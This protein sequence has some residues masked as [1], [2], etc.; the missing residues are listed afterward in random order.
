MYSLPRNIWIL[1]IGLTLFMSLTVAIVFVGGI[2]G[3]TLAP[4][5]GLSTLP[6]AMVVI[7]TALSIIPVNQLM[8]KFGRRTIFLGTCLYT[9]SVIFL[10]IAALELNN[11][12]LFCV[13]AFLFGTN[14][15]VMNQF[16]FAAIESVPEHLHATAVSTVLAGGL[17]S[18][19]LAP[20]LMILGKD[21]FATAFV[22]SFLLLSCCFLV[23]FLFLW[24]YQSGVIQQEKTT[25]SGRDLREIIKQNVFIV[26]ISSAI[27]GYMIMSYIMTATP[28]SMHI[29]DNFSLKQTKFVI[30]T[31]IIAMFLP[32]FFTPIIVKFLGLNRMLLLGILSYIICII[33]AYT[34]HA[35]HHYWQALILLG[36]GWNFLFIGSTILLLRTYNQNEKFKIQSINDFLV[37]SVQ[38]VASLSA[39]YFIF[40]FGWEALLLSITPILLLQ[41]LLLLWWLRKDSEQP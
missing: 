34:G 40:N 28:M 6:V 18:A 14:A 41:L 10:A 30:Q 11:F 24:F 31:H 12:Y 33:I 9:T 37:F 27:A 8:A 17:L 4:N 19:F 22:G 36:I 13:A 2:I 16:R 39:G 3:Q 35:L 29:L 20:E 1:S 25:S 32:S 26:A 15:A 23:A 21:Y 5:Q 38:A 7:G